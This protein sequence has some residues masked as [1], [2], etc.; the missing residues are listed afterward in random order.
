MTRRI[1]RIGDVFEMYF[2]GE[3]SVQRGR[4]PGV[5]VQNNVGNSHSPNLIVIPLTSK[6]NK[7][8]IPT[9]V[10]LEAD[11]CGLQ[12]DSIAL[13]EGIS[14]VSKENVFDYVTTLPKDVF[15]ELSEAYCMATPCVAFIEPDR[16]QGAIEKAKRL[17]IF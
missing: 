13:C 8:K 1:P 2:N 10:F 17:C 4:R 11:K 6:I 12:K 14:N 9:H 7:H 16:L 3:G 15:S 5:I